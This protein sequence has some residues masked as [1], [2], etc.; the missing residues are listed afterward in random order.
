MKT[1][2]D[3]EFRPHETGGFGERA[4][5]TFENGYGVS[6]IRGAYSY[7]G[8][9]GLFELAVLGLDGE[10]AYDTPVTGDVLGYLTP[11]KVTEA[12]NAVEAL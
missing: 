4:V 9:Q 12:M 2:D 10:V 3:L 1:F 8:R 5:L 11:E 6:V 7:G